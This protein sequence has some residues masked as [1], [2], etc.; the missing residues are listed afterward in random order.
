M[1]RCRS[2]NAEIVYG[3]TLGGSKMPFDAKPVVG[4][5]WVKVDGELFGYDG[6]EGIVGY[7]SHFATC[8][9]AASHRKTKSQKAEEERVK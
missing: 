7:V 3:L 2:C 9:N 1:K 6:A 5:K 4:G 8:P